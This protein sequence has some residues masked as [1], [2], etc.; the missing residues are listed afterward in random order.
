[1]ERLPN[2][3][4]ISALRNDHKAVFA[5]LDNGP[6]MIAARNQ[7]AGVLVSP[8]WWDHIVERLEDQDALIDG[9]QAALNLAHGKDELIDADISHLEKRAGRAIPA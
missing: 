1:M 5:Q 9:L 6:V 4:A 2:M 7:P 8:E 3:A